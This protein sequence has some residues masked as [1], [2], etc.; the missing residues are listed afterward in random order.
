MI[1]AY[2]GDRWCRDA[3][4]RIQGSSSEG[5]ASFAAGGAHEVYAENFNREEAIVGSCED[6]RAGGVLEV[7]EQREDMEKGRRVAVPTMVMFSAE[8][9]GRMHDVA[10]VWKDWIEEGVE[11]RAT[12]IG[13]GKGHYL[14]EEDPEGIGERVLEW[15]K[16]RTV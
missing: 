15:I 6:Y 16:K 9:L 10:G 4:E 2:G 14:P 13:G 1:E 3:L 12:G 5:Q 8:K 7:E 11:Y